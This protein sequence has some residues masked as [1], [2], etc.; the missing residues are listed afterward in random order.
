M[1]SSIRNTPLHIEK[2]IDSTKS[3]MERDAIYLN[4]SKSIVENN[5]ATV[6]KTLID[7]HLDKYNRNTGTYPHQAK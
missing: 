2:I 3:G 7:T 6:L 1:N 4:L 5:P